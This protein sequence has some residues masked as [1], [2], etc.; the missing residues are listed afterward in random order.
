M[1]QTSPGGETPLIRFDDVGFSYDGATYALEGFSLVLE[2][3][4]FTSVIGGNGSGKSTFAKLS[5]ALI[6][7][8][9]G[10]VTVAGR[11]T[12]EA[13]NRVHARRHVGMVFQNPDD[14]I[15]AATVEEDVAFGPENL[16]VEP[17]EIRARVT[18][19]LHSVGL[20]GFEK[21]QVAKLSGG[22][23]QR[24]AIAGALAMRPDALVLD[25][26]GAM[27][28]P[29]GRAELLDLCRKL[30]GEGLAI[31]LITHFMEEAACAQRVVALENGRIALDGSPA[32]V[33]SQ[34][35]VLERL[36]LEPPFPVRVSHALRAQGVP[37]G[38]C[39]DERDLVREISAL[40]KRTSA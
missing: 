10:S 12:R 27:L 14:Q 32:E 28:D 34:V 35:D 8:T 2:A 1:Q 36:S 4:S 11:D 29:K 24:V 26:A 19:A 22:E 31:V 21:A 38:V 37:L 23:K 17:H 7:P 13:A 30:N 3:G 20:D 15:V 39:T 5:N 40:F 16:G 18:E 9:H 25:E 33:L 6:T